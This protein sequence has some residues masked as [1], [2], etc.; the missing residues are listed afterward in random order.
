MSKADSAIEAKLENLARSGGSPR[1]LALIIAGLADPE[2]RVRKAAIEAGCA[3]P[4]VSA[5]IPELISALADPE[6]VGRRNAAAELLA[7]MGDRAVPVLILKLEDMDPD[8]RIFAANVLG[9]IRAPAA[10]PALIARIGDRDENVRMVA[11]ERLGLFDDPAVDRVLIGLLDKDDIP[12]RFAALE[13]LAAHDARIPVEVLARLAGQLVLRPGVFRVLRSG[14]QP[15]AWE[16]VA[17]GV[18]DQARSSREMATLALSELV[19]NFPELVPRVL[20]M[21]QPKA[22]PDSVTRLALAVSSEDVTLRRATVDVLGLMP[23]PAAVSHLIALA[24]DDDLS[25]LA[26]IALA[27]LAHR[28]GQLMLETWDQANDRERSLLAKAFGTAQ[29][30]AAA[31]RLMAALDSGYG[32]L[33]A[34]AAR[35]LGDLGAV[36]AVTDLA[37]LLAHSYP[38]VRL[39]A[40]LALQRMASVDMDAVS[41]AVLPHSGADE[42]RT[43]A[44]AATA[45]AAAGTPGA[46]TA[47]Y[48]LLKDA[49][50][51]VRQAAVEALNPHALDGAFDY[52]APLL[53]DESAEVRRTVVDVIGKVPHSRVVQVLDAALNDIDLWVQVGAVRSLG[54]R[55]ETDALEPVIRGLGQPDLAP[56]LVAESLKAIE[57]RNPALLAETAL[58]LLASAEVDV[59]LAALEA[60]AGAPRTPGIGTTLER[61]LRHDHWD[62]RSKAAQ[63]YA[64]HA[65]EQARPALLDRLRSETDA[66]VHRAIR[67]ALD[68]IAPKRP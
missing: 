18:L 40:A 51:S 13:A 27:R 9:E 42:A 66:L 17:G 55:P 54:M 8:V 29:V 3:Y 38:D 56:P 59:V 52:I 35:A 47:L 45:L 11:V 10:I 48:R 60:L 23:S 36:E 43:R 1:S 19:Q 30:G 50:P 64:L 44:A 20:G 63:V 53:A 26:A 4:D 34:N 5:L 2:W 49:E 25:D 15:E 62:V 32:H 22:T 12:L 28:F 57:R 61:L 6:N 37:V 46:K 31:D 16:I 21:L 67:F 68:R 41:R 58:P 14:R 7:A 65:G 39:A 33:I 24:E